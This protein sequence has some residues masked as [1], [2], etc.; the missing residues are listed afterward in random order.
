MSLLIIH[1][2]YELIG[3]DKEFLIVINSNVTVVKHRRLDKS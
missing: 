3:L 2:S 1:K